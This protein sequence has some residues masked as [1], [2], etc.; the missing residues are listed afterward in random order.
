MA[1][2]N[3]GAPDTPDTWHWEIMPEDI[4]KIKLGDRAIINE[5]F[6]RIM[7]KIRRM[8]AK[9]CWKR[10][11]KPDFVLD[12]VHQAYVFFPS[13]N[14]LN[15]KT[16]YWSI[17]RSFSIASM[18]SYNPPLSLDAPIRDTDGLTLADSIQASDCSEVEEDEATKRAVMMIATQKHLSEDQRDFLC[19][20]AFGIPV[21]RGLYHEAYKQVI[22]V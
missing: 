5:V 12:C 6:L 22:T 15:T 19:A 8:A 17:R 14:F 11:G 20:C 21:H 3:R 16:L 4:V 7:P 18:A 2:L 10:C 13:F 9:Y 1:A